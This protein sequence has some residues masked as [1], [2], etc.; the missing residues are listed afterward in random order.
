VA[1]QVLRWSGKRL[2]LNCARQTGKSTHRRNLALH[3]ALFYR[4]A[5]SC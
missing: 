1:G 5:S 2:L 3:Q 4:Q